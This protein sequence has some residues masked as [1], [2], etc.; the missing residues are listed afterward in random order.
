MARESVLC[1]IPARGG[2]KGIPRKN[3]CKVN[4][5][6]LLERAIKVAINTQCTDKIV[7]SSDDEEILEVASK[8]PVELLR[9]PSKYA[10]DK[11]S[12]IQ[13]IKHALKHYQSHGQEFDIITLLEPTSPFRS[14]EVIDE[15]I[16]K[17]INTDANSAITVT[18]LE[19]HPGY[20]FRITGDIA[21]KYIKEPK[22]EFIRRQDFTHLKR[23][24]GCVYAFRKQNLDFDSLVL[25]PV[26][27]VEMESIYAVNIDE[28]IDLEF[29][30][31]LAKKYNW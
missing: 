17:L 22:S 4:G 14:A 28:Q 21:D 27:V 9:R 11:A 31:F 5:V 18:Q 24:N 8:Y 10:D 7:V 12:S 20:I 13:Y 19:R 3:L 26:R 25:D 30:D 16:N 29:A 2:S 15:C 6:S 23:L 1:L